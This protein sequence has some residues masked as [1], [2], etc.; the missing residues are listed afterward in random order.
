MN[1]RLDTYHQGALWNERGHVADV[2][3]LPH[4]GKHIAGELTVV[5]VIN[6]AVVRVPAI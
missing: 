1:I 3:R 6:G 5:V 2:I 4:S